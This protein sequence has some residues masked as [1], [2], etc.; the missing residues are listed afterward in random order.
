MRFLNKQ[1]LAMLVAAACNPAADGYIAAIA[2]AK[3]FTVTTR[4][5][6]PFRAAGIAVINPREYSG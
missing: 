3:G 5:I 4:E 1:T 2:A 6:D